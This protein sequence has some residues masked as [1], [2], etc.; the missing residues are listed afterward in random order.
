[1]FFWLGDNMLWILRIIMGL[2]VTVVV[3]DIFVNPDEDSMGVINITPDD[4]DKQK[5]RK[6]RRRR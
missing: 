4:K 3:I 1:M 5:K 6:K 2:V